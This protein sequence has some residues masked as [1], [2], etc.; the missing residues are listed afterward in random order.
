MELRRNEKI[1]FRCTELEKDA[2]AE[3]AARCSLSV[4]EYCRSLS[5]G[6][7]PRDKLRQYS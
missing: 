5:L 4:S 7:R 3:Q 1:T 2:L 6:G